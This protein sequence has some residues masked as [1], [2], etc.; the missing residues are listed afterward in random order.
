V[1]GVMEDQP[2][3]KKTFYTVAV[4]LATWAAFVGTV[5]IVAVLVTSRVVGGAPSADGASDDASAS[6]ASHAS[7]VGAKKLEA[8]HPKPAHGGDA[9]ARQPGTQI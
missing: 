7:D 1:K 4:M 5:S 3:L 2:I 9:N 6:A 8:T